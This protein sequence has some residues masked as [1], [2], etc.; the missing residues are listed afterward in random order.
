MMKKKSKYRTFGELQAIV[1]ASRKEAN[2][3]RGASFEPPIYIEL[4]E[5]AEQLLRDNEFLQSSLSL[6]E[7][8]EEANHNTEESRKAHKP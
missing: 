3:P 1:E 2:N 4:L 5:A 7:M 8:V 6:Y